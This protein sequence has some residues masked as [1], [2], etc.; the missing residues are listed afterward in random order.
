[1]P[2]RTLRDTK[3][4]HGYCLYC[5]KEAIRDS[6]YEE[7]QQFNYVYCDC[8]S[9]KKEIELLEKID[10]IKSNMPITP[11]HIEEQIEFE[12]QMKII[13]RNFPK[14]FDLLTSSRNSM[15]E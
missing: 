1:M 14:H 11:K 6:E 7:Y 15:G 4:L 5:G 12:C 10:E 3:T 8:A 2:N 13:K 9:A